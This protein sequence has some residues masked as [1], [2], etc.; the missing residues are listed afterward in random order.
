MNAFDVLPAPVRRRALE[1][2]SQKDH[3]SGE[4]VKVVE[5]G[6][7]ISLSAVSQHLQILRDPGFA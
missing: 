1:L 3:A 4:I 5:A 6:F 2:T 7:G